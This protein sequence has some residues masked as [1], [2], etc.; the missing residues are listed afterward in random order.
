[1]SL[2]LRDV[3]LTYGRGAAAVQALRGID[4]EFRAGELSLLLGPSGSGKTSLLQ[5]A[6]CLLHP[7][8]GAVEILGRKVAGLDQ[9]ALAAVRRAHLGFVFQHY[10][11]FPALRAWENVGVA[12]HMKGVRGAAIRDRAFDLLERVGLGERALHFPA[13]LSGGQKQRVAV[14][15][16]LAGDP[17]ILLADEPTAAL[18]G[19]TGHGVAELLRDL[20]LTGRIVVVVTHDPRMLDVGHRILTLEDGR[21]T[22]DRRNRQDA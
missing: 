10:H 17:P 11:L 15:R 4:L 3:A 5:V 7:T 9:E 8:Q 14:A 20:A 2:A 13:E 18:D 19:Q 22:G 12:L 1:V 6:G 21:I 16:A